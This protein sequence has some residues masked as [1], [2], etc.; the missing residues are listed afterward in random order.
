M[1]VD[2]AATVSPNAL[3]LCCAGELESVTLAVTEE[4]PA[5][6]GVPPATPDEALSV[7]PGGQQPAGP[8]TQE[9]VAHA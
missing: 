2:G 5:A 6:V 3:S 8:E 1:G 4:V 9:G 7:M